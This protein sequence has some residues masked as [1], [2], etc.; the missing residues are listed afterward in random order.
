LPDRDATSVANWLKRH[1]TIQIVSRDRAGVYAEGIAHGAPQAMQVADRW[2][3]LKNL[4]DTIERA[5]TPCQQDI[6]E[7]ARSLGTRTPLLPRRQSRRIR[8][9][10]QRCHERNSSKRSGVKYGSRATKQSC[11]IIET[12]WQYARLRALRH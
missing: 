6:R 12:E 4:G 3:L 5:L 2:H 11:S 8:T 10:R 9:A 7:V 1:R